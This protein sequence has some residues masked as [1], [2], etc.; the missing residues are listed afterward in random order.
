VPPLP[1]A[2]LQGL[3]HDIPPLTGREIQ[4]RRVNGIMT[5]VAEEIFDR[6]EKILKKTDRCMSKVPAPT[7]FCKWFSTKNKDDGTFPP[8]LNI[9][10]SS[11][12]FFAF[13]MVQSSRTMMWRS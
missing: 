8:Q 6:V 12:L 13:V 10:R 4:K 2:S 9:S 1:F 11:K 7:L 3:A 5:R